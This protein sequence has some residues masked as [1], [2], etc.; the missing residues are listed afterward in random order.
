MANGYCYSRNYLW[1]IRSCLAKSHSRPLLC[2]DTWNLLAELGILRV[3]GTR[4]GSRV[5][6]R[7][8]KAT[9]SES[10]KFVSSNN[11][12]TLSGLSSIPV[13]SSLI[14]DHT[15][16][17]SINIQDH[18]FLASLSIQDNTFC[19]K[20]RSTHNLTNLIEIKP[21]QTPRDTGLDKDCC[22]VLCTVNTRSVKNKSET[23]L[24]YFSES[25][26]DVFALTE[27]WLNTND[28]AVCNEF[29]PA[30]FKFFHCPRKDRKG[31]G[32]GLLARDDITVRML[33]GG[34]K[35]SFEFSEWIFDL[36]IIVC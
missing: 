11:L 24:D 8:K 27:T 6:Q 4:A 32:T 10:T 13:V 20:L 35:L 1:H 5:Q 7:R 33:D 23:L 21:T 16:L 36:T 12:Q 34:E 30:G 18:T 26:A 22:T 3:R 25:G 19:G 29:T 14:Q 17:A 15:F 9:L 31:G 2:L 28:S